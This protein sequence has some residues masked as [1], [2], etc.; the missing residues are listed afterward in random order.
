MVGLV[1]DIQRQKAQRLIDPIGV[2]RSYAIYGRLEA[3]FI[4]KSNGINKPIEGF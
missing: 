4:L 1:P 2:G 3:F